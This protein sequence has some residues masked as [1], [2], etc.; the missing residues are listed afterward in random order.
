[1]LLL[2]PRK[3]QKLYGLN[4]RWLGRIFITSDVT[5]FLTQGAGSGVASSASW[6]GNTKD[7]GLDIILTGLALQLATFT[8]FVVFLATLVIRARR[9][10][11]L[12]AGPR[13]VLTGVWIAAALVQVG[14]LSVVSTRESD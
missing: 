3:D 2:L 11:D 5:S 9:H 13:K 7:I 8:L 1:V 12:T 10:G 14:H 4:P 6:E